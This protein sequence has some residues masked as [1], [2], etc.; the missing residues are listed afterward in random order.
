[1]DLLKGNGEK[2]MHYLDNAATTAVAPEVAKEITRVMETCFANPSSLYEPGLQSELLLRKSRAAVATA[3]GCS[4]G[5]VYFTACGTESNNIA[6]LG[7][8]QARS[9]WADHIVC[10]GYEHP[11]VENP[12]ARL[13]Q[14]GWRVTRVM[15]DSG[16]RIS[17][18]E[19]AKQ[20]TSKT[21]L[22]AAMQVN[23]E[24]GAVID[25]A[26][27]AKLVKQANN[28]TMVHVDG[29]QAWL[30]L[31]LKLSA[32]QIDSYSVS[33]HK[34]H[35]PKGIGALYLRKGCNLLPPFCGGGQEKGIRP[36]TEN[37]PYIAGMAAA[38]QMMHKTMAARKKQISELNRSLRNAL[39]QMPDITINSPDD[40]VPEVLNFSVNGIRSETMLH[41]LEQSQVYV[42]SGSAC[43]KGAASH[44]LGAMGLANERIDSA[45]RVSFSKQNTPQDVE[46][47]LSGLA[48]GIAQIQKR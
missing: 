19:I 31:P 2:T 30:R 22:V 44:T 16:G 24:T 40:A 9:Q 17:P 5:E 12:I 15:P 27:L 45:L 25:V 32:T 33:G 20:V 43:S 34:I 21:A 48:D 4:A 41:F 39:L 42:S 28:R 26:T 11:S 1:M 13:E 23:N 36:G 8:V 37:L 29:V 10:T 3:M 46:A 7:A 18:E 35:A 38:A 6:I 47:L 14:Q